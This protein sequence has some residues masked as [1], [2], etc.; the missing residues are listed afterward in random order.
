[1][2]AHRWYF[3]ITV[4]LGVASL[5]NPSAAQKRYDP[6][7][8]DT[9]IKIGNINPYSGPASSFGVIGNTEAAYFNKINADGGI[10]GRRINFISYDD[11]YSPPKTVEQARKLV[12]SDGVLLIFQS[13]GTPPNTAIQKYMNSKRVPQLFVATG[14]TKWNDPQNFP[15]TIGWQPNYQSEGHIFAQYL[16]QNNPGGKIGILYQNDDYGKDYVKGLK[17]GLNG[18]MQIVAES[19]YETT[20][21]TIDSQ[22]VSL[23][24]SGADVFYDV[25]IPKFAAQAIKKAAE[26][27]WKPIHLLN[28]VSNSVGGVIKPAGFD[29]SR[30]ILSTGY[31][32]DP[33]DPQW[34][35]DPAYNDWV[36]FMDRYYPDGDRTSTF[37]VYG[38]SA[39]QT[40]VQ[41]IKQCGDNLTRDN[42]MRQAANLHDLRLGMLLP[43]ITINTSPIDFAP[44]KQMQM[45]RFNGQTWE[46]FGPILN[47]ALTGG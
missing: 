42:V 43:G 37:T 11:S 16:L 33:T 32:K 3:L 18:K 4:I 44:I 17:D 27:E 10:N 30:G 39:A 26:I 12:E 36:A 34:K 31:V 35:N 14:A 46:L 2:S 19:S 5:A 38:Y 22:I 45:E 23:K 40:M 1:M 29:I 7:A 21:P 25:T 41:V 24:A 15:W 8:S 9:E 6:G 13:L 28:S 20:D 47:G